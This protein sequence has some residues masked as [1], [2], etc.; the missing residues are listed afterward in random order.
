MSGYGD[1]R[2]SAETSSW[3]RLARVDEDLQRTLDG[4]NVEQLAFRPQETA[5]NSEA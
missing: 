3:M 2:W 4:L 5:N 1:G